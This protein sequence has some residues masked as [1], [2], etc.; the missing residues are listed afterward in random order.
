MLDEATLRIQSELG[1]NEKLFWSGQPRRGIVF[2]GADVFWIPFSLIPGAIAVFWVL[3]ILSVGIHPV[4]VF[5]FPFFLMGLYLTFGRFIM[6]AAT[7]AKT[8]YG[9]T[10]ERIIIIS[11]LFS[12]KIKS[13]NL[14]TLSDVS[15]DQKQ[16]GTGTITFGPIHPGAAAWGGMN[17]GAGAYG[18]LTPAFEMIPEVKSVYD[19]IRDAQKQA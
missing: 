19:V 15:M 16:N 9:V 13:L 7:R 8:Y 11:G 5:G 6:D 14:R 3:T 2:R 10:N 12:R 4:I 17:W 1:T 18:M